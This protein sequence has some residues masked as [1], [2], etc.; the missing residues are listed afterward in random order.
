MGSLR[1]DMKPYL[2]NARGNADIACHRW[3]QFEGFAFSSFLLRRCW[4]FIIGCLDEF[5]HFAGAV[6]TKGFDDR[7]FEVT[8]LRVTN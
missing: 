4:G 6:A 2:F 5:T 3:K 1:C 8:L 7:S